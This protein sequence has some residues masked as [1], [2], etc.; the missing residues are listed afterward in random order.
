LA[1]ALVCSSRGRSP[2]R[3][4][5]PRGAHLLFAGDYFKAYPGAKLRGAPGLPDKRED[6]KFSSILSDE[7]HAD[8]QGQVEQH[9]FRGAPVLN[10][11]VFFH[12]ATRTV[13]F[14]DFVF[15]VAT[16]DASRAR[17]FNWVT[18]AA[19]HFG[20]RRLIQRMISDR[21]AA[22]ASVKQILLWASTV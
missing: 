6:L 18:G 3:H 20:P 16:Q 7:A 12:P 10:E 9:L 22:R 2:A 11:V 15:N 13:I 1:I 4:A 14:T 8:W 5:R 19:G 21:A 17:V